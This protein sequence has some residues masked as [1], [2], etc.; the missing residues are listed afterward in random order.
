V[1]EHLRPRIGEQL[2]SLFDTGRH[3]S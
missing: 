3:A 2:G 1:H